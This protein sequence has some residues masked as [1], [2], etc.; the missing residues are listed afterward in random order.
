MIKMQTEKLILDRFKCLAAN[1]KNRLGRVVTVVKEIKTLWKKL[2]LAQGKSTM[3]SK[4]ENVL[5][6]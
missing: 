3:E 5:K 2:N 6:R 1:V 4:I